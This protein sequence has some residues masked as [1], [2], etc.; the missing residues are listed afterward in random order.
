MADMVS[1]C[2][3]TKNA[4]GTQEERTNDSKVVSSAGGSQREETIFLFFGLFD[5]VQKIL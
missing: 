3:I 2:G 5:F 4:K 1:V